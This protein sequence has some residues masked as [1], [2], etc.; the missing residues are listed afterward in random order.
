MM[1]E[2]KR[3]RENIGQKRRE[4]ELTMSKVRIG[5]R[6][7]VSCIQDRGEIGSGLRGKKKSE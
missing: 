7:G 6:R 2:L 5:S 3:G 1:Q 4:N